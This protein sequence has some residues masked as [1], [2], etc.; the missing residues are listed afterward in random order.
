MLLTAFDAHTQC[1]PRVD[2][3]LCALTLTPNFPYRIRIRS[4]DKQ[5]AIIKREWKKIDTIFGIMGP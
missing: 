3:N 2:H 4:S 5:R 1:A